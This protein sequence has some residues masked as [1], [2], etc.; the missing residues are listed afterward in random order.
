[1][2]EIFLLILDQ[3]HTCTNFVKPVQV[4]IFRFLF[5]LLPTSS[6]G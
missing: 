5:P 2:Q 6:C 1:M 4:T 3:F